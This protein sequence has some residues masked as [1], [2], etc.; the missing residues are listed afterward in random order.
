MQGTD[1]HDG[2]RPRPKAAIPGSALILLYLRREFAAE[3][4]VQGNFGDQLRLS[5]QAWRMVDRIRKL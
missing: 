3:G 1:P 2:R 5:V 4:I